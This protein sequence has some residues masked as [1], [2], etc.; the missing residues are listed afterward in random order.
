MT[1]TDLFLGVCM[2][3]VF[4]LIAVVDETKG[5]VSHPCDTVWITP[6]DM[7]QHNVLSGGC[8][9]AR[10]SRCLLSLRVRVASVYSEVCRGLPDVPEPGTV[11]LSRFAADKLGVDLHMGENTVIELDVKNS[12]SEL[13]APQARC[14]TVRWK[15]SNVPVLSD[16]SASLFAMVGRFDAYLEQTLINTVLFIRFF[17][18]LCGISVL[19]RYRGFVR[20][21]SDCMV[22]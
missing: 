2:V 18:L 16:D 9:K 7:K 14:V 6:Y 17:K 5:G 20:D 22:V 4:S 15:S 3:H 21:I 10:S 19:G 13:S 1:I 12:G 11:I 8:I